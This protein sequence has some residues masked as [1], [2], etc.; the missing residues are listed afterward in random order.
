ME[1]GCG[2]LLSLINPMAKSKTP[3]PLGLEVLWFTGLHH[4]L[5]LREGSC[6]LACSPGSCSASFLM[7]P[8]T[9]SYPQWAMKKIPSS[10]SDGG[11]SPVGFL[12]SRRA[13]SQQRSAYMEAVECGLGSISDTAEI[14]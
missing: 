8:R 3:W 1:G 14:Y 4:R 6:L 10:Q 5:S 12:I 9:T 11:S 7:L 13:A 2:S